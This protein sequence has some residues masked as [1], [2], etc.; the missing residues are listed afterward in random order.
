MAMQ[1][2]KA[3]IDTALCQ[4][5]RLRVIAGIAV[6]C[7]LAISGCSNWIKA[8]MLQIRPFTG[9]KEVSVASFVHAENTATLQTLALAQQL[10]QVF[11]SAQTTI[12]RT[13]G[14][15]LKAPAV[16]VCA[17]ED[18]YA[19]YVMI[20]GSS[21][22][23]G[24]SGST[25]ILNAVRLLK[26]DSGIPIFTHELSHIFWYQH[27]QRCAPRWW[28]EGMAV[29]TSGGGAESVS[30]AQARQLLR[31]GQA[32]HAALD[33]GCFNPA[34]RGTLSWAAYYRQAAMF[35]SY[36]REDEPR[37]TRALELMRGGERVGPA[38]QSA[39]A[40]PVAALWA[41]WHKKEMALAQ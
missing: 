28:L 23:T 3:L 41:Q 40:Q 13:H 30:D 11:S 17:S 36:L 24:Q 25:V 34:Q 37:F 26:N 7:C 19:K 9:F 12:E 4:A 2:M 27:G 18:C 38:L 20:P 5:S 1:K 15:S 33:N 10:H 6:V 31:E 22:E 35:V 29:A 16:Y 8:G 32:F 14:A 21:A 39:Y